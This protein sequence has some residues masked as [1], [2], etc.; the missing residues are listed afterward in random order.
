M[1]QAPAPRI[2]IEEMG[3]DEDDG[4]GD[5]VRGRKS[6]RREELD[7]CTAEEKD[8]Y[9]SDTSSSALSDDEFEDATDQEGIDLHLKPGN[10][11]H[12]PYLHP[13]LYY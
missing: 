3:D 2:H 6:V 4:E 9:V 1:T 5:R 11:S 8:G 13:T 7:E 10:C 12:L